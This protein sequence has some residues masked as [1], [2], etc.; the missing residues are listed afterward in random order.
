MKNPIDLGQ[1]LKKNRLI[2]CDKLV[3]TA[4][5]FWNIF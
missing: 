3:K 1:Y 2:L 4:G 5:L